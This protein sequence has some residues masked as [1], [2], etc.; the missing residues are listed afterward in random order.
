MAV[1]IQIKAFVVSQARP[2]KAKL[3]ELNKKTIEMLSPWLSNHVHYNVSTLIGLAR[4][5]LS[6]TA[7]SF[8]GKNNP[9]R[10]DHLKI[11]T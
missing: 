7:L 4:L 3:V 8:T 9:S 5:A 11:A 6:D 10:I 1:C 2:L